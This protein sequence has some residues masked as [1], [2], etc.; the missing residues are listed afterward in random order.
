MQNKCFLKD[1]QTICSRAQITLPEP[2]VK[3]MFLPWLVSCTFLEAVSGSARSAPRWQTPRQHDLAMKQQ[4]PAQ[5]SSSFSLPATNQR[6]LTVPFDLGPGSTKYHPASHQQ[7]PPPRKS[8]EGT[9]P[10][11]HPKPCW[12]QSTQFGMDF[13]P[14]ARASP[15]KARPA[16]TGTQGPTFKA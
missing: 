9:P 12:C 8:P 2:G 15:A 11:G 13:A 1:Y 14:V 6:C 5:F 10:R 3:E 4:I 16:A 7:P